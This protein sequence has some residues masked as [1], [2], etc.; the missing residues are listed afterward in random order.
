[1]KK[2]RLERRLHPTHSMVRCKL[3]GYVRLARCQTKSMAIFPHFFVNLLPSTLIRQNFNFQEEEKAEPSLRNVG[4]VQSLNFDFL[5]L[6]VGKL[7][8]QQLTQQ[9]DLSKKISIRLINL[10]VYF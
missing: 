1:M 3:G 9:I 8:D 5:E 4:N 2:I 6:L 10:E 7:Y